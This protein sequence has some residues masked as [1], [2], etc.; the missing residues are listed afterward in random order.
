MGGTWFP[1]RQWGLCG[2]TESRL[3]CLLLG[4]HGGPSSPQRMGRFLPT[5]TKALPGLGQI[6]VPGFPATELSK[7]RQ[8]GLVGADR[9]QRPRASFG[10]W[11]DST[12]Q[13]LP[14]G[15]SWRAGEPGVRGLGITPED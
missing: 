5:E 13:P 7:A 4:P 1:M 10:G 3:L 6:E 14:L 11:I 8:E 9:A 15:V 2:Q 12:R